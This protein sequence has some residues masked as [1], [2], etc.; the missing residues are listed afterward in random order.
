[1]RKH[2]AKRSLANARSLGL[3]SNTTKRDGFLIRV[4]NLDPELEIGRVTAPAGAVVACSTESGI[5]LSSADYFLGGFNPARPAYVL[6]N[7]ESSGGSILTRIQGVTGPAQERTQYDPPAQTVPPTF[8]TPK[9]ATPVVSSFIGEHYIYAMTGWHKTSAMFF[10]QSSSFYIDSGS[11]EKSLVFSAG[12]SNSRYFTCATTIQSNGGFSSYVAPV[13]SWHLVSGYKPYIVGSAYSMTR[14][15][16]VAQITFQSG[17]AYGSFP[18]SVQDVLSYYDK[19][20]SGTQRPNHV[21]TYGFCL[22]PISNTDHPTTMQIVQAAHITFPPMDDSPEYDL[23]LPIINWSDGISGIIVHTSGIAAFCDDMFGTVTPARTVGELTFEL[24]LYF[25]YPCTRDAKWTAADSIL[26][27]TDDNTVFGWTRDNGIARFSAIY[28]L[29]KVIS[30]FN[31]PTLVTTTPGVRPNITKSDA[32]R[33]F[34]VCEDTATNTVLG[35]HTGSPFATWTSVP[36]PATGTLLHARPIKNGENE[37]VVLGVIQV[38]ADRF[39]AFL[40]YVKD[41]KDNWAGEWHQAGKLPFVVSGEVKWSVC[42]Y[43]DDPWV[44]Y[45]QSY[46]QPPSVVHGDVG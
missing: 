19:P 27:P 37:I 45:Q 30:G 1:M 7:L 11:A 8:T 33:Y 5:E 3:P 15:G 14:A 38:G 10:H 28:G 21:R 20:I 6:Q 41:E 22:K 17:V 29:Q 18:T 32:T 34:C 46:L 31:V 23:M 36:M 43:G 44:N 39:F 35:L 2:F 16:Q 40:Y 25:G 26:I 9:I 42:L 24:L 12:S 4:T 13:D